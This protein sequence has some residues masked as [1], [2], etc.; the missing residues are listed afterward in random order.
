[1][2]ISASPS[3]LTMQLWED[4]TGIMGATRSQSEFEGEQVSENELQNEEP[5]RTQCMCN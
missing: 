5:S 4:N 3:T 1:M 2:D